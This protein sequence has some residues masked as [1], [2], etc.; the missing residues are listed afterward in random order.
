MER[1]TSL[2]LSSGQ[3][4]IWYRVHPLLRSHLLADLRRRRPE[5]VLRLHR[6]AAEW[7]ASRGRTVEAL[8]HARQGG[9]PAAVALL[10]RQNSGRLVADGLY[11]AMREALEWL[12]DAVGTD[13]WLE[14]LAA[15]VDVETGTLVPADGHLARAETAWPP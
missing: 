6:S 9:D 11:G 12:G 13:P 15:L 14:L 8:A 10:L 5:E 2:V 3:G 7:Y 4:R 1:D